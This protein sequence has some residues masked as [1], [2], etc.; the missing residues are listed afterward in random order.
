MARSD[1]TSGRLLVVVLCNIREER[2][3]TQID[4]AVVTSLQP[5]TLPHLGAGQELP[6]FIGRLS[7]R[8]DGHG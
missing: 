8:P 5:S 1:A 7:A 4:A 3:A 6:S 2:I